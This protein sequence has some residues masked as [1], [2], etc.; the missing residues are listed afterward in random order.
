MPT[1]IKFLICFAFMLILANPVFS[2]ENVF[3][4]ASV[5]YGG[6]PV[7]LTGTFSKP[8]NPGKHPVVILL[9]GCSGLTGPVESSLKKHAN[10]LNANGFA[11]LILDSFG[12]RGN[13]GGWVCGRISRL[14]SARD[15]R[16]RDVRDASAYL[17]SREDIDANNIFVM[18]QSNGGSTVAMIAARNTVKNVRAAVAYYPWCGIVIKEPLKPLLVLSGEKDDWTSPA[19]CKKRN[20]PAGGLS[21]ITYPDAH[22]SFDLDIPVTTYKGHK[23]GGNP[24]AARDAEKRMITFFRKHRK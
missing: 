1:N 24:A 5:G 8:S 7:M 3:F 10:A 17:D 12:P 14:A 4:N 21:V 19:N 11:S 18:G 20:N 16:V 9:H 6:K 23:V 15:Y 22:H 2:A 13:S